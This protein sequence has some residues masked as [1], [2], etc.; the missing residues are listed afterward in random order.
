MDHKGK[1]C[2]PLIIDSTGKGSINQRYDY[3]PIDFI[4]SELLNVDISALLANP[5][6]NFTREVNEDTGD[7]V[8]SKP[9]IAEYQ[10]LKFKVY[11]NGKLY[12]LG[13][14]HKYFNNGV[15]NYND[16]THE[17]YLSALKRIEIDFGIYDYQIR[18]QTLEYGVN[19]TPPIP[20][21]TI[22]N[23]CLVYKTERFTDCTNHT[24]GVCK[25]AI[26]QKFTLKL[27]DKFVQYRKLTSSTIMRI[28]VK[29]TNWSFYRDYDIVT[30]KD[31]NECNKEH[32][33]N[34]ILDRW[35]QVIFY[36]PTNK[37]NKKYYQYS[38]PLYWINEMNG[39]QRNAKYR[40]LK[41][42]NQINT[43][44]SNIKRAISELI[45]SK[46]IELQ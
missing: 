36:D 24:K 33:L 46:I 29:Q 41:K 37:P 31:F 21:P 12:L 39:T 7:L 6:L 13:S 23:H 19:I 15:H 2:G 18:I 35:Q 17:N 38:N 10:D 34:S 16:F 43:T 5:L 44:G 45:R 14:I 4:K 28:E 26:Y 32:F 30:L 1:T 11:D 3:I 42:L 22:L 8:T 20:T 27:Y 25:K 9:W 40:N